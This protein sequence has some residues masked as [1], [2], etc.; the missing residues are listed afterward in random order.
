MFSLKYSAPEIAATILGDVREDH[1]SSAP[2]VCDCTRLCEVMPGVCWP[3]SGDR[4]GDR[5]NERGATA[6]ETTGLMRLSVPGTD[7]SSARRRHAPSVVKYTRPERT[8][9]ESSGMPVVVH[10]VRRPVAGTS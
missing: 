3:T 8:A 4:D 6:A 7:G 9:I 2:A 10:V 1:V 5:W